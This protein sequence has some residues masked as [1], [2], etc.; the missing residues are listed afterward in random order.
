MRVPIDMK[1][2]GAIVLLAV[3]GAGAG[4]GAQEPPPDTGRYHIEASDVLT[5]KY[6]YS[7][8]YD[9]TVMVQPDGFISLPIVGELRVGGL[10][11]AE[12]LAV[13][14]KQASQRLRDP[15]ITVELKEFQRPRFFVG[16]EVGSPGEFALRG[17][18]G[19]MQ[20]I[21]MAGGFKQSAKHSQVVHLR[22][23][24]D[25]HAVR[26]I[27]N[28]KALAKNPETADIELQPGDLLFVP[29]NRISKV[30]TSVVP[31]AGPLASFGL[32]LNP[33]VD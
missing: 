5:V 31:L 15:E 22:Q 28:A 21:A 8:E 29:Q 9:Y 7:P 30:M 1:R 24:D 10:T 32:L 17:R 11:V 6:R 20:A 4:V 33:F 13:I 25:R 19:V 14:R 27:V 16:G 26:T 2:A 12:A 18:I 23:V 3:L